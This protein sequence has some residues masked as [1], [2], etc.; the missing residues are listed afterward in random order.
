MERK[1]EKPK[2]QENERLTAAGEGAVAKP[3]GDA[4]N[5]QEAAEGDAHEGDDE[6]EPAGVCGGTGGRKTA[7]DSQKQQACEYAGAN[8]RAAPLQELAR[9]VVG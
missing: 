9:A 6:G 3:L 5:E 8:H 7:K 1:R 4:Q 2:A